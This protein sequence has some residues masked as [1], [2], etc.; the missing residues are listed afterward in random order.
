M[1]NE[2]DN[3]AASVSATLVMELNVNCP[4][5]GKRFDL[6]RSSF[7]DD[8]ELHRQTDRWEIPAEDRLH[9]H[10]H[11]PECSGEFEVN[12]VIW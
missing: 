7:N 12:G 3:S 11:C 1:S 4:E 2:N 8:G 9:A 5:C 6:F 10:V